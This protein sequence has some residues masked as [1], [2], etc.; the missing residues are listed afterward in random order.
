[1]GS[2][3]ADV[4]GAVNRVRRHPVASLATALTLT[5][6]LGA[7]L[8]TYNAAYWVRHR[9]LPYGDPGG[10]VIAEDPV[11]GTLVSPY[12]WHPHPQAAAVFTSLAEYHLETDFL[13]RPGS[14]RPLLM[15]LVTPEFFRVLGVN[16]SFQ[17]MAAAPPADRALAWMPVIISHSLWRDGLGSDRQII[18]KKIA[19]RRMYP[20]QFLVVGV[21]PAEMAFPPGVDVWMP[22]HLTSFPLV[23][24]AVPPSELTTTIARLRPGVSIGEAENAIRGWSHRDQNWIWTGSSRLLSLREFLGGSYFGLGP[25]LWELALV[26]LVLSVTTA[27]SIGWLEVNRR[28]EELKLRLTLGG[29]T[30]RV[31]RALCIEAGGV[32]LV[33]APLALLLGWALGRGI[34]ARFSLPISIETRLVQADLAM[35]LVVLGVSAAAAAIT[36]CLAISN[37]EM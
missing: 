12:D 16:L 36:Q 35:V 31:W 5:A 21:A 26:F 19:L 11:G 2:F 6:G 22:E 14:E 17:G 30:F 33:A 18:G 34:A 7:A 15:A 29:S 28:G 23:Q 37:L 32:L 4:A 27:A 3:R 1:L 8:G 25:S 10:I 13:D 24:A 20:Y 9:P